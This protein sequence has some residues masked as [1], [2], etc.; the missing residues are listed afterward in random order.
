EDPMEYMESAR[1]DSSLMAGSPDKQG[2]LNLKGRADMTVE[3]GSTEA[4][5]RET[6]AGL[7]PTGL[8]A[9][10]DEYERREMHKPTEPSDLDRIAPG[11]LNLPPEDENA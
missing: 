10:D 1:G 6:G 5:A 2:D 8:T 7:P 3:R 11:M 9:A 4:A